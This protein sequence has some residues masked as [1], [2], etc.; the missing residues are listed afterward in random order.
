MQRLEHEYLA[1]GE[2]GSDD[3]ERGVLRGGADQ[4]DRA[5]FHRSQEG[6]LLGFVEPVNLIDKKDRGALGSKQG[7]AFGL[8][9]DVPHIFYAGRDGGQ[10]IKIAVQRLGNDVGERRFSNAGRPPEYEGGK[11]P[12]FNHRP[13]NAARSD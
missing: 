8:V 7:T 5:V 6:V 11:I 4:D 2:E 12:A 1:A 10:L 3:L 9:N 13:E